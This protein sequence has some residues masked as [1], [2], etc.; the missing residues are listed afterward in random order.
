MRELVR[1]TSAPDIDLSYV[2]NLLK[3]TKVNK[4]PGPDNISGRVLKSCASQLSGILKVIFTQSLQL[5]TV[6]K[7]W[8]HATIVPVAKTKSPKVRPIALTSLVMKV[9]EK[10]VKKEVL[11]Q[12]NGLLDPLQFAY[13]AGRGVEDANLFLINVLVKHL[14]APKTHARLL[15]VDF[16]S[17]FNTIQ[18]Y[19]LAE[20]LT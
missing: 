7:V 3:Q 11:K 1:D 20:K 4:S 13:Q 2:T 16:S 8:K 5:Q 6:P 17:A 19:L 15:F 10:L 9:F 12:V 14:E 18:P